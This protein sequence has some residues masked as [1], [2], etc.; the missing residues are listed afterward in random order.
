MEISEACPVTQL[1][2]DRNNARLTLNSQT[3][4]TDTR[5]HLPKT[6]AYKAMCL[7]SG[8]RTV[9]LKHDL[10]LDDW[11][12]VHRSITLVNFQL[13]A[14]NSLFIYNTFY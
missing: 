13:D 8:H 3:R 12:T 7:S 10:G 2:Q 6:A 4:Y 14:Q 11:L 9:K 1:S 5:L